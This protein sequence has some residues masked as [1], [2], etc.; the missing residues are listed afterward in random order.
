MVDKGSANQ[1]LATIRNQVGTAEGSLL[2]PPQKGQF[3]VPFVTNFKVFSATSF[4]GGTQFILTFDEPTTSQNQIDHYNI[5]VGG[6]TGN[7]NQYQGPNITTN[8]PATIR[9]IT[10]N[11]VTIIFK[12]QTVLKSGLISDLNSSPS[13][14]G[15]TIAASGSGDAITGSL[16]HPSGVIPYVSTTNKLAEDTA[17]YWDSTNHRQLI[18]FSGSSS[19][20]VAHSEEI[21]DAGPSWTSPSKYDSFRVDVN[22]LGQANQGGS[23]ANAIIG[24]VDT[25]SSSI[26]VQSNGVTGYARTASGTTAAVGVLGVGQANATNFFG[27]WGG[28]FIGTNTPTGIDDSAGTGFNSGATVYGIEVD[29]NVKKAGAAT[30]SGTITG[31][32]LTGDT[33]SAIAGDSRAINVDKLG[34]T[35]SVAWNHGFIT[36]DAAC[37]VGI[38][39]GCT[40]TGNGV[41]S[42]SLVLKARTSGGTVLSPNFTADSSGNI[43]IIPGTNAAVLLDDSTGSSVIIATTGVMYAGTNV[44]AGFGGITA[45]NVSI[46][47]NQAIATRTHGV[48]MVNGLNSNFALGTSG[49]IRI[50]GPTAGFSIGGFTNGFDGRILIIWNISG[51]Q[52]TIVNNDASSTAANRISTLTGANVVLRAGNSAATFIYDGGITNWVLIA[53]N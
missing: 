43:N 11:A 41:G 49:V 53:T 5:M 17:N 15:T 31:I 45:P 38:S 7:L 19:G 50:G 28:N 1:I 47:T 21:K 25:P 13:C 24:A 10:A 34:I 33:E 6:V 46:D 52:L 16:T 39:L 40:G 18:G 3:R 8:S 12:I 30:Y 37:N 35:N 51:Q 20:A 29:I 32:Q 4:F 26:F 23:Q 22:A 2:P 9:V 44:L 36:Q 14:T 48:S 42:Q 27:T